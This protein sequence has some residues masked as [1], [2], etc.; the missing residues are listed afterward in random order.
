LRA[1]YYQPK[2]GAFL[3]RDP[4]RGNA[5]RPTSYNPW[6]Y[7]FDNPINYLDPFGLKGILDWDVYQHLIYSW[8][9][10][11]RIDNK[12]IG[13]SEIE[14]IV[15]NFQNF[16]VDVQSYCSSPRVGYPGSWKLWAP[17]D[18][19][20][21]DW[22]LSGWV[23]YWQWRAKHEGITYFVNDPNL[24]KALAWKESWVGANS[25]DSRLFY[26][27]SNWRSWL[28]GKPLGVD[29]NGISFEL[30]GQEREKALAAYD[31]TWGWIDYAD[32]YDEEQEV[33]AAVRLLNALYYSE[34]LRSSTT[35][36]K[37]TWLG[38][39]RRFGP[40]QGASDYDPTY[41]EKVWSMYTAG[42]AWFSGYGFYVSLWGELPEKLP[43]EP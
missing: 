19:N 42:Y 11:T 16:P 5:F 26:I 32:L 35:D 3:Q 20:Q 2:Q 1:R 6:L 13:K 40:S 21:Y 9:I 4:W 29:E 17:K 25:S 28:R 15:M 12:L 27:T 23:D 22:L 14:L 30:T 41:G 8:G 7:V 18:Y 37:T 31:L 33:G 36:T 39:F 24:L 34:S 43:W 10:H 38:V